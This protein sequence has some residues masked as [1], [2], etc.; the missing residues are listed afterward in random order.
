MSYLIEQAVQYINK[1]V[2]KLD[3]EFNPHKAREANDG[4]YEHMDKNEPVHKVKDPHDPSVEHH[5]WHHKGHTLIQSSGEYQNGEAMK[6]KGTHS[7]KEV[8]AGFKKHPPS[9]F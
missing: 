3:E 6:V 9:N 1:C 7:D 2:G 8:H 5:I 4:D